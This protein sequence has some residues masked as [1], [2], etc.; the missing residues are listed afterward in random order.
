MFLVLAILYVSFTNTS[1]APFSIISNIEIQQQQSVYLHQR[2]IWDIIWSCLVTIFS[3]AWVS[4]HPNIPGPDDS[5][6]KKVFQRL[7]LMFWSIICP[8]L[9]TYWAAKQWF[10][11]RRLANRYRGQFLFLF[12]FGIYH[13]K[14]SSYLVIIRVWMDE[15][16]WILYSDGRFHVVRRR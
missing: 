11:A 8:E 1:A 5:R 7:E 9:I 4:V 14:H 6:I 10:A 16:S 2:T 15:D 13:L 12:F 3:C